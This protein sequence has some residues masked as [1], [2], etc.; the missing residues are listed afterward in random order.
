MYEGVER[1]NCWKKE[2]V[3]NP[4]V[5][6]SW[7]VFCLNFNSRQQ[8]VT[9]S[10]SEI[11]GCNIWVTK[12]YLHVGANLM[13]GLTKMESLQ[14]KLAKEGNTVSRAATAPMYAEIIGKRLR[15]SNL[16]SHNKRGSCLLSELTQEKKKSSPTASFPK[17]KDASLDVYSPLADSF[18]VLI[19]LAAYSCPVEI[20]MHRLTT[21][22]APL[23]D[24]SHFW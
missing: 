4:P 8:R 10:S 21:E 17:S 9:F 20:F 5:L 3:Q 2:T 12:D 7:F 16:Y 18:L 24:S 15:W 13:T 11:T 14:V 19:I 22:K 23:Q 6:P 1:I